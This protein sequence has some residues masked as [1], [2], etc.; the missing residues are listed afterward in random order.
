MLRSS[1]LLQLVIFTGFSILSCDKDKNE[2]PSRPKDIEIDINDDLNADFKLVYRNFTWT[3]N[4]LSGDGI[5]GQ[6]IP[7]N[8]NKILK[9]ETLG[10]LVKDVKDTIFL[11]SQAPYF[12]IGSILDSPALVSIMSV[13]GEWAK[14]WTTYSNKKK[15]YYYLGFQTK[16]YGKETVGWMKLSIDPNSGRIELV[17]HGIRILGVEDFIIIDNQYSF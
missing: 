15:D 8:N 4:N 3:G 17:N 5:S 14:E 16:I 6:I 9:H 2:A 12:W 7:L 11:R 13:A 10:M 1:Q